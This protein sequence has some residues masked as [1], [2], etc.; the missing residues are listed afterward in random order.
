MKDG[1]RRRQNDDVITMSA[2]FLR[3]S[4][5]LKV[6]LSGS[7]DRDCVRAFLLVVAP[8]VGPTSIGYYFR[9]LELG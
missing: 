6:I 5:L 4:R 7:S 2:R 1:R 8:F 3:E 9:V